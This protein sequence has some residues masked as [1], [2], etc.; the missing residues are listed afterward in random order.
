M[1]QKICLI[2]LITFLSTTSYAFD[3]DCGEADGSTYFSACIA[4]KYANNA[5]NEIDVLY[6]KLESL[7]KNKKM[8]LVLKF[9]KE[10]QE[11]W[12]SYKNSMCDLEQETYG[13]INSVSFGK[14]DARLT[15]SR[16]EELREIA[17]AY[18]ISE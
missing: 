3:D 10:S 12:L 14:C 16:L 7:A 4:S 2:I 6:S 15:S 18:D 5:K 17:L 9:L 1:T 8:D 11:S 13:G